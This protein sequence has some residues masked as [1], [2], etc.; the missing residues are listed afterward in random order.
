MGYLGVGRESCISRGDQ[1][2]GS[3]ILASHL[4]IQSV[5]GAKILCILAHTVLPNT[6]WKAVVQ[7]TLGES[8]SFTLSSHG[9]RI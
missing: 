4:N 6:G 5:E 8:V 1:A 9:R 7:E 2:V 3:A